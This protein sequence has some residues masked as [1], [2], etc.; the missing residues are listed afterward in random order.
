MGLSADGRT[1]YYA[2]GAQLDVATL[3]KVMAQAGAAQ[4]FQLDANN[5]WVHFAAIRSDGTNLTAEPL[6]KNMTHADR[7]LK[8]YSRDFFYVTTVTR[9]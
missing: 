9:P 1:L 4:A 3:T 6:L 7:Y 2:A 8:A 5:Y